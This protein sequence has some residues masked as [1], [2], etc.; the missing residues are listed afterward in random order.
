MKRT[1][2]LLGFLAAAAFAVSPALAQTLYLHGG[3]GFPSSSAFND[4]YNAGFNAGVGIGF[5]IT[6][7]VEGVIR[8]SYDRF[9]NDVSGIDNFASYSATANLKVNAPTMNARRLMPYA[10]GGAGL[11]RIGVENAFETEFGLQFGAGVGVRATPRVNLMVEP[12]YVVVL[13]D[14][15]STQ[16]FPIRLGL[17]Y[18]L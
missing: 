18:G 13:N 17:S 15:E 5:P 10:L 14:G 7:S 3:A 12:N 9:G 4:A 6:S 16:Y 11:F 1:L 8:G 2:L